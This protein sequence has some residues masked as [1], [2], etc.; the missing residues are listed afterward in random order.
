MKAVLLK[1]IS[2]TAFYI[3]NNILIMKRNLLLF[4]LLALV[5]LLVSC[6]QKQP[7]QAPCTIDLTCSLEGYTKG[8]LTLVDG[9]VLDSICLTDGHLSLH[10]TDSALMPYVAKVT[11]V[12]DNDPTDDIYM[13]IVVE[14]GT[15]TVVLG[16]LYTTWGTPLNK[17]MQQ[18]FVEMQRVHDSLE[19]ETDP[20]VVAE[21][22][23]AFFKK[24]ILLHSNDVIGRFVLAE[25]G[26][27]MT[28]DDGMEVKTVMK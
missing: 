11:L 16:E 18:F 5:A 7:V 13:P 14:G 26:A 1:S 28:P 24:Q 21:S 22:Y 20:K 8:V 12:N 3:L 4:P 9:S 10:R 6:G 2:R 17:A 23:S 27:N 19:G 25:Y 15:V